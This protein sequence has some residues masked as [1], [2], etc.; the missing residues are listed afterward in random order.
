MSHI[1]NWQILRVKEWVYQNEYWF[2][3]FLKDKEIRNEDVEW[4]TSRAKEKV[5]N[6]DTC[7]KTMKYGVG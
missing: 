2:R 3:G 7:Q 5:P 6:R 4:F 1:E